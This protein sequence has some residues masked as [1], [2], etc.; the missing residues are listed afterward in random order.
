VQLRS[1]LCGDEEQLTKQLTPALVVF[2]LFALLA[3]M[4]VSAGSNLTNEEIAAMAGSRPHI[5]IMAAGDT[6]YN[7]GETIELSGDNT[8]TETTYL[9]ITGPGLPED[10]AQINNP[11]PAHSPLENDNPASYQQ[12]SVRSDHTWS[13]KWDTTNYVLEGGIYRIHAVPRLYD[14]G[15][16]P[17]TGTALITIKKPAETVTTPPTI[18]TQSGN[19]KTLHTG[20]VT[21]MAAG[22]PIHHLGDE[23]QFS[24]TNTATDLTY[25]FITGPGLAEQ[26][27]RIHN[28]DPGQWAVENNNID[29]FKQL[30]VTSDH[31]WS[32]KWDTAR[33]NLDDGE[34]T[35]YAV[36]KPFDRN[37][38]E[39]AAYG[40][41]S[42]TITKP[43]V[44][45]ISP[46][47]T[48]A[49]KTPATPA[50]ARSPGCGA[51]VALTGIGAAVSIVIRRH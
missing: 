27:S 37:H 18:P 12:I 23:I 31:T 30:G 5:T 33:Y 22:D 29:S 45:V 15:T 8:M 46:S 47:T 48:L 20:A 40:T 13:W 3:I 1:L 44:S 39:D 9:F 35:I 41:T 7:I 19:E 4:Q 36:D 16:L 10:G 51:L 2:A 17:P 34:Y 26:G 24:G 11:D 25:L 21:I 14:K 50:P 28:P 43:P 42:I 32:W 49:T 38:L 6:D